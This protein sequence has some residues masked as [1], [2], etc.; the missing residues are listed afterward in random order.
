MKILSSGDINNYAND[1]FCLLKE[2]PLFYVKEVLELANEERE[3]EGEIDD[4]D[5]S[6]SDEEEDNISTFANSES[7]NESDS[8]N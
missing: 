3:K 4:I 5:T 6:S 2:I 1:I 8:D 7:E